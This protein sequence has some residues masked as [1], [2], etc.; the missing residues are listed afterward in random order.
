MAAAVLG[1]RK[2]FI[3]I[4]CW[5]NCPSLHQMLFDPVNLWKEKTLIKKPKP[6][7]PLPL[8]VEYSL[9]CLGL[10][11]Q[12][13]LKYKSTG[14]K[15][16]KKLSLQFSVRTFVG[17]PILPLTTSILCPPHISVPLLIFL[18]LPLCYYCKHKLNDQL[19]TRLSTYLACV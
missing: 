9:N 4:E 10:N 12:L 18:T 8:K 13:L 16:I 5:N 1:C 2:T 19:G 3:S 7:P 11:D 17:G 14:K 6:G 15:L